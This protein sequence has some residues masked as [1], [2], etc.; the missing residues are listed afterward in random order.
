MKLL[1]LRKNIKTGVVNNDD[2]DYMY[3]NFDSTTKLETKPTPTGLSSKSSSA[4][5]DCYSSAL[6]LKTGNMTRCNNNKKNKGNNDHISSQ[7]REIIPNLTSTSSSTSSEDS[8]NDNTSSTAVAR[9]QQQ[10]GQQSST[11]AWQRMPNPTSKNSAHQRTMPQLVP[12]K[13]PRQRIGRIS[14]RKIRMPEDEVRRESMYQDDGCAG[15]IYRLFG[16]PLM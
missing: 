4:K 11:S 16:F 2:Y 8:G 6:T 15:C 7:N 3:N 13:Q 9:K 14:T 5:L 1:V 10:Q 12:R